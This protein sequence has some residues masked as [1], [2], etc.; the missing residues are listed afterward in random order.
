MH[1]ESPSDLPFIHCGGFISAKIIIYLLMSHA[2]SVYSSKPVTGCND[3]VSMTLI[4]KVDV[5]H[6]F[7]GSFLFVI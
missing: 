4:I 2:K 5:E 1:S 3:S 6:L 7:E